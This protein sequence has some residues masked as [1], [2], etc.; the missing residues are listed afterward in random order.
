[1]DKILKAKSV[2]ALESTGKP[3]LKRIAKKLKNETLNSK[4]SHFSCGNS[5]I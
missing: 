1:M 2:N 4:F 3:V 5:P